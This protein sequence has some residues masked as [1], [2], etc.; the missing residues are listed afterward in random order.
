V[1]H[2]QNKESNHKNVAI[3]AGIERVPL[4]THGNTQK[5]KDVDS[6]NVDG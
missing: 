6:Y 4:K 2:W 1:S 3:A 5:E